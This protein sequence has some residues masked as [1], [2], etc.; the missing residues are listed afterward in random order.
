ICHEKG[1][2]NR[3]AGEERS[4]RT[5]ETNFF[6][7]RSFQSLEDLNQ[8]AFE[9]ATVRLDNRPIAKS[10]LIPAKAFEYERDHL[11][12]LPPHLPAPYLVHK[13]STDQYGYVSFDGNF[14]WV[15]GTKRDE[16]RVFQ[17]SD[18]LK[19]Y[20]RRE[21]L[22]EY[23][24]PVD[25]MKNKRF[26]PE[27]LPKPLYEPKNR[28]KPTMEEEK[29][30]RAMAEVVGAYLDFALKP[31]GVQRHRFVR[32]LFAL[33]RKMTPTLFIKT[34]ERALKYRI[35]RI[36]IIQRIALLYLNQRAETLPQ[37]EVDE[38]FREREAYMEGRL[39]EEPDFS[40]YDKLLEEG[41]G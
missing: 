12:E 33:A 21:F 7:G 26:S 20:L 41:N 39:T 17:Y 6:P 14:Y 38:N 28:K 5:V 24:L 4:F 15:P 8:Q 29:R 34:I 3:K 13:R 19:I 32:E 11:I 9:W 36:E 2:A 27:G 35:S 25:G 23:Q 10:G 37:V 31:K 40:P 30:L 18:L 16:V 1:H 22:I